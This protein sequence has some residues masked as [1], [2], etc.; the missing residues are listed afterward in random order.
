MLIQP[1]PAISSPGD[2]TLD[3]DR[4]TLMGNAV[5]MTD[6][7]VVSVEVIGSTVAGSLILFLIAFKEYVT[8]TVTH[9]DTLAVEI[10]SLNMAAATHGH[11]VVALRTLTTVVPGYKEIVPAVMLE[12]ERCLDG[13]GTGIVGSG[14][15][16]WVRVHG[17]SLL[18]VWSTGIVATGDGS[19]L[20]SLGDVHRGVEA[21]ELDAVPE[22]APDEPRLILIV[23]HEVG[24][25]GVP[26]VT[27]F[28]RSDNT[29][30]IIPDARG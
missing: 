12:D 7:D 20:F 10:R 27:S 30:L 29:T 19:R 23:D 21:G 11:A 18:A 3:Q 24:V 17:E 26:V 4:G 13:I 5:T 6:E 9:V 25:D 15:L 1:R 22:G 8:T 28:T 14:I 16:R 2:G